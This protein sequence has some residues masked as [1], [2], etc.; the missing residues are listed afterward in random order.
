MEPYKKIKL[1]FPKNMEFPSKFYQRVLLM[2]KR[3]LVDFKD[4]SQFLF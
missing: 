4:D 2:S 1:T 3:M